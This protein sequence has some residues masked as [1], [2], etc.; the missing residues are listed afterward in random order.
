MPTVPRP[1]AQVSGWAGATS[2]H[3]G[4]GGSSVAYKGMVDCFVRTLREEGV[5]A[6]FKVAPPIPPPPFCPPLLRAHMHVQV[7]RCG[8]SC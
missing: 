8:C 2:L 6:F 1:G 3:A 4:E 5:R 7:I